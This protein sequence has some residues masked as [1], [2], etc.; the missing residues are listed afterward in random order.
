MSFIIEVSTIQL[1]WNTQRLSWEIFWYSAGF[2]AS[3][4][5]S[6]WEDLD[7]DSINLCLAEEET[8]DV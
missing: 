1:V 7:E 4:I 8:T 5:A 2:R 3:W 6:G